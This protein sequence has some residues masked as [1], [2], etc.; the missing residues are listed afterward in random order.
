MTTPIVNWE[1]IYMFDQ[2]SIGTE[3]GQTVYF[4][5]TTSN[6]VYES[7]FLSYQSKHRYIKTGVE[8]FFLVNYNEFLISLELQPNYMFGGDVKQR[9]TVDDDRSRSRTRYRDDPD[10]Y[11]FRRF[12]MLTDLRLQYG[13]VV[14]SA[15]LELLPMFRKDKGPD[16]QKTFFSIGLTIP[17]SWTYDTET[18]AEKLEKLEFEM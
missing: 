16:I 4:P 18:A 9:F 11:N 10:F 6:R 17:P 5:D 1:N 14:V 3:N 2:L 12:N 13:W 15:G 7:R 8:F